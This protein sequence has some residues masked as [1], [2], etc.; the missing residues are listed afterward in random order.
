MMIGAITGGMIGGKFASRI[1][2]GVLRWVVIVTG[3][4]AALIYWLK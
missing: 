4:A 1:K 2:P 3:F